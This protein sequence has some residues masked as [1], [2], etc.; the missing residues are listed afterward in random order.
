MLAGDTQDFAF[1]TMGYGLFAMGAESSLLALYLM[2]VKYFVN[3]EFSLA[4]GLLQ[5][6]PLCTAYG[7]A[8]IV[9]ILYAGHG[10]GRALGAGFLVCACSYV[11]L[12]IMFFL[13]T[14]ADEHDF[15]ALIRYKKRNQYDL[16]EDFGKRNP[17]TFECSKLKKLSN[18]RFWLLSLSYTLSQMAIVNALIIAAEAL[19]IDLHIKPINAIGFSLIPYLIGIVINPIM[20]QYLEKHLRS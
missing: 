12:G 4:N 8:M 1:L 20:G 2:L 3:F 18:A 16:D 9:P 14:K 5:V 17:E 7:G 15:E 19:T 6:L 13:D 10:F 11:F